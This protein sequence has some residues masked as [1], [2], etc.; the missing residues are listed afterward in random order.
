M[1]DKIVYEVDDVRFTYM[2]DHTMCIS[3]GVN[4]VHLSQS[5]MDELIKFYGPAMRT[6]NKD[7]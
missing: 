4:L 7:V 3:Q 1:G 6:R 2:E 5:Q